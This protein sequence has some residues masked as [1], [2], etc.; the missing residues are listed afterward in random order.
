MIIFVTAK[1]KEKS[2][3]HHSA[4]RFNEYTPSKPA[5]GLG[6]FFRFDIKISLNRVY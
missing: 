3:K 2:T 6:T 5:T 4:N 1:L